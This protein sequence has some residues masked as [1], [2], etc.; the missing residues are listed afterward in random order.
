[1]LILKYGLKTFFFQILLLDF[2]F[3]TFIFVQN[4]KIFFQFGEKNPLESEKGIIYIIFNLKK[5]IFIFQLP[6]LLQPS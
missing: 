4:R 2:P 6:L 3:W 5:Y 1:M